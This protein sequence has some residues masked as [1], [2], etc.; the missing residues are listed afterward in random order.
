MFCVLALSAHIPSFALIPLFPISF[1]MPT[2][3]FS[4][5]LQPPVVKKLV[6]TPTHQQKKV[7]SSPAP[8][9]VPTLVEE[10]RDAQSNHINTGTGRAQP[11]THLRLIKTEPMCAVGEGGP[12]TPGQKRPHSSDEVIDLATSSPGK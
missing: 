8:R 2:T 11:E 10:D 4:N 9:P 5:S 6:P 1:F 7:R 3:H 12:R